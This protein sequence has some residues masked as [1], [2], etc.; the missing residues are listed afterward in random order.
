MRASDDW[1]SR[2]DA[3]FWPGSNGSYVS[4]RLTAD[5]HLFNAWYAGVEMRYDDFGELNG[6]IPGVTVTALGMHLGFLLTK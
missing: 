3:G 1:L 6:G 4:L 2:L 5:Y